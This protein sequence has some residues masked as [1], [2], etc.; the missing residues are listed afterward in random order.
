LRRLRGTDDA[1][2]ERKTRTAD[3]EA[4]PKSVVVRR[5]RKLSARM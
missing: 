4:T 3:I 5:Y 1:V 2:S